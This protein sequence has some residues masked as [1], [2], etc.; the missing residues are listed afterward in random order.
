[1]SFDTVEVWGSSPH[2]PTIS[3]CASN[4]ASMLDCAQSSS[5]IRLLACRSIS[6]VSLTDTPRPTSNVASVRR[7][8]CQPTR[9]A[10]PARSS[11]AHNL[12][13]QSARPERL[14]SAHLRTG[15]DVVIRASVERA[16]A[17]QVKSTRDCFACWYWFPGFLRLESA[18]HLPANAA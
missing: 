4:F 18:Y 7:S 16:T 10:M 6:C 14:L 1:M 5:V 13:Q 11:G 2:V 17:P 9:L 8:V 3:L 15:E 12:A